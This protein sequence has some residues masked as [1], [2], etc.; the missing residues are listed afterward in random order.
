MRRFALLVLPALLL[1]FAIAPSS[2]SEP[3]RPAAAGTF[4]VD[5]VHSSVIFRVKHAGTSWFYG[6]FTKISGSFTLDADHPTTSTALIEIAAD[7]IDSRSANRDQHLKSEAFFN[8]KE[9]PS[10]IFETTAVEE[11]E[12]GL[13]LTGRLTL[14]G[15]T[16]EITADAVHV[17]EG[18]FQGKRSGWETTFE[19]KRSDFGMTYGVEQG[20]LGD[21]VR[22]IVSLEGVQA[23]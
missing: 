10:I 2:A 3:A 6:T 17:G 16:H 8:A 13:R 19:I 5:P 1:P 14:L 21:D 18:E 4:N 7:S 11:T 9:F 20:A 23:E 15:Q 12:S 22:V